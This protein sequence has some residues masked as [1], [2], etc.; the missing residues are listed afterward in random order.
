[1]CEGRRARSRRSDGAKQ[2]PKLSRQWSCSRALRGKAEV[3]GEGPAHGPRSARSKRARPPRASVRRSRWLFHRARRDPVRPKECHPPRNSSRDTCTR[4][5][6]LRSRGRARAER[7]CA[8]S[9]R[10]ARPVDLKA[11]EREQKSDHRSRPLGGDVGPAPPSYKPRT[12]PRKCAEFAP[13]APLRPVASRH[14]SLS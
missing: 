13:R 2:G 6:P 14:G 7:F 8:D 3:R 12:I 1:M 4:G 11:L 9:D 10:R 5:V